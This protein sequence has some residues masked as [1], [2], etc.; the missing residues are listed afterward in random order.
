MG[1]AG[2]RTRRGVAEQEQDVTCSLG[3][4]LG[5]ATIAGDLRVVPTTV[6]VYSQGYFGVEDVFATLN[7]VVHISSC[8]A[9]SLGFV[10]FLVRHRIGG[11]VSNS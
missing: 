8:V 7:T 2:E 3:P 4:F 1:S 11:L 9:T 10:C 5:E 6:R